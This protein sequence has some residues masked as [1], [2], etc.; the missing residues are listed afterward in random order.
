LTQLHAYVTFSS[1]SILLTTG[2]LRRNI[3]FKLSLASGLAPAALRA[4]AMQTIFFSAT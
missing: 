4:V 3:H 2:H 1:G